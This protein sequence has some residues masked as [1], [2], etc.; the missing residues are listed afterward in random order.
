V[1][2]SLDRAD[3]AS[4]AAA[5]NRLSIAH[6]LL[7]MGGTAVVLAVFPLGWL[8]GPETSGTRE[9]FL[10][11]AEQRRLLERLS[12]V[13]AA[14]CYGAAVASLAVA[15]P[16][17][18]ERRPGFP[19]LPG[20]WLLVH[21]G[22]W[23]LIAACALASVPDDSAFAPTFA[24]LRENSGVVLV[25]LLALLL[26]SSIAALLGVRGPRRW[27]VALQAHVVAVVLLI[28]SFLAA[29]LDGGTISTAL[30]GLMFFWWALAALIAALVGLWDFSADERYDLFH[31][32]GVVSL[33]GI[34][35]HP[36]LTW[37]IADV[38]F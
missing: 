5:K 12:V 8:A 30:S 13:V 15:G 24:L 18:L 33:L 19:E 37:L 17:L 26:A 25:V 10:R 32:V 7:W 3:S 27:R 35:V 21:L 22:L 31:W 28:V 4:I 29:S 16:R 2:T 38:A 6:L 1:T 34:L 20:H 9:S 14:P 36:P 11:R 23:T